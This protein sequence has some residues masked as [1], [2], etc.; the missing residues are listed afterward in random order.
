MMNEALFSYLAVKVWEPVYKVF[1]YAATTYFKTCGPE[2]IKRQQEKIIEVQQFAQ[3]VQQNR[4]SLSSDQ[5]K[6]AEQK[7]EHMM[8]KIKEI[9]PVTFILNELQSHF[10]SFFR[11]Q[12]GDFQDTVNWLLQLMVAEF[13]SQTQLESLLNDLVFAHAIEY[14][15]LFHP[16]DSALLL[17]KQLQHQFFLDGQ[18]FAR[19]LLIAGFQSCFFS[20]R[21]F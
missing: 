9:N 6:Q 8:Q 5:Q 12:D 16:H 3:Y 17:A 1:A 20:D 19:T 4:S 14:L 2:A 11:Q 21:T 18:S 10:Q 13:P 7:V 15:R